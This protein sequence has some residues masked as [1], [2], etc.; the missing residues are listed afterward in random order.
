[1]NYNKVCVIGADPRMNYVAQRFLTQGFTVYNQLQTDETYDFVVIPPNPD[2]ELVLRIANYYR[3]KRI[4][5]GF[6]EK[7]NIGYLKNMGIDYCNYL[8]YEAVVSENAVYTAKGIVSFAEGKGAILK[9]SSCL[10]TGFGYCGKAIANELSKAGARVNV[11]V[12]NRE[13]QDEIE[14]MGYEYTNFDSSWETY[15]DK[16]SYV[17][18]TVPALVL[19]RDIIDSL[20]DNVMIFDIASRP[21]GTDF[22]YCRDNSIEAYLLLGIPGRYYPKEAG[23]IIANAIIKAEQTPP[24][25]N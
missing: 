22:N 25:H 20:S 23:F 24:Y 19:H 12:R 17:F 13:L 1:M 4:Y 2:S 9:E 7:D 3:C 14:A 5:G 18:N 11:I 6:L 16:F 15:A 8:D 21:G 10:V